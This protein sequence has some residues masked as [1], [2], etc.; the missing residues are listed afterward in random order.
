MKQRISNSSSIST[1]CSAIVSCTTASSSNASWDSRV[2]NSTLNNCAAAE[3]IVEYNFHY[4]SN[5][6]TRSCYPQECSI[7]DSKIFGSKICSSQVAGYRVETSISTLVNLGEGASPR[8]GII[9]YGSSFQD[10][11]IKNGKFC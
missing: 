7:N 1:V 9:S 4:R 2:T 10:Y 8:F 3:E 5:S 11:K 6:R